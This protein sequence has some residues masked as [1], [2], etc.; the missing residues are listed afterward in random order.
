[1]RSRARPTRQSGISPRSTLLAL[2]AT[3]SLLAAAPG[4]AGAAVGPDSANGTGVADNGN[5]VFDFTATSGPNGEN[6]AG[7]ISEV[8]PNPGFDF[9]VEATVTCLQVSGN[10][11]VITG[12]ILDTNE[13]TLLG[14]SIVLF[15][16]DN[17]TPGIG[18]DR[19]DQRFVDAITCFGGG[20]V[21]G[22][23]IEAGEIV[24]V[25]GEPAPAPCPDDNDDQ[26]DCDQDGQG[27]DEDQQGSGGGPP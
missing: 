11:A 12:R 7:H 20:F 14:D 1:M 16:E 6:P 9:F 26:G 8:N 21:T 17:G 24:V 5:V 13:P 19:F 4:S 3:V 22:A 2:V 23:P 27:D 10:R 15:V 25:D 18:I